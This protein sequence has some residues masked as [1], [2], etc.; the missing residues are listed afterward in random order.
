[1]NEIITIQES[2]KEIFKNKNF[3]IKKED[4][5]LLYKKFLQND[6]WIQKSNEIKNRD[7]NKCQKCFISKNLI[8]H[9]LKYESFIPEETNNKYLITLCENCHSKIHNK[10]N[11]NAIL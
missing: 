11:K 2:I 1:M 7:N 8:V 10:E 6:S 3:D 9:H 5:Q 4:N